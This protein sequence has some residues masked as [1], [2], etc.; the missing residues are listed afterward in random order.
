MSARMAFGRE[1]PNPFDRNEDV[2]RDIAKAERGATCFELQSCGN[3]L[4]FSVLARDFNV[5][6]AAAAI[7]TRL[8]TEYSGDALRNAMALA[9]LGAMMP[10]V[11]PGEFKVPVIDTD[12]AN[13]TFLS[14]VEAS[15]EGQPATG[16]RTFTPKR[17]GTIVE[18]SRQALVQGG[19]P[20]DMILGR[21]I[22]NKVRSV[23]E[24]GAING[25]GTGDNPLGVRAT[26]NINTVAGGT[27]GATLTW[28]H[29][30]DL[31]YEPA[32]DNAPE[33]A[34]GYL[35]NA[36]TRRFLKRTVRASGLPFMW[37]GG[38]APLNDRPAAVSNMVPGNLEKGS[39]G[40]VCQSLVYGSDWSMLLVPI[41]GGV[42]LQVDPYTKA[43]TGQVRLIVNVFMSAGV[44]QP[45]CF[46]TMD[47][48]LLS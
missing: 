28:S 2:A 40:A 15:A 6:Q 26:P 43:D 20:L 46:C 25:D 39:S 5:S 34:G 32:A 35:V 27:H 7:P 17:V 1:L 47:D 45:A 33:A 38:A 29:V 21:V 24:G 8:A 48:A 13:V 19:K 42:E 37:E 30:T 18:V 4:P 23:I 10:V 11:G 36:A 12:L 14:E 3:R 9:K 22:L 41:F 31:E 16:L 44:L